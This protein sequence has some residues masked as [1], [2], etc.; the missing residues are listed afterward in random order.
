MHGLQLLTIITGNNSIKCATGLEYETKQE[1]KPADLSH[2]QAFFLGESEFFPFLIFF[3]AFSD[4]LLDAY[5]DDE[6]KVVGRYTRQR[7]A[8]SFDVSDFDLGADKG[9]IDPDKRI[10]G[11]PGI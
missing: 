3:V 1:D 9:M 5:F 11:R 6:G 7:C 4:R 2:T 8:G 10:Y